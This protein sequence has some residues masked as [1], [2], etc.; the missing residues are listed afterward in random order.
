MKII[1]FTANL[2][3]MIARQLS[4]KLIAMREKYPVLF[5]TG[6]RQSGKTT[7]LNSIFSDL[8]YF[9]LEESDVRRFA[10]NDPRGFL[11]NLP[12][13]AVLDEAQ[14]VPELFSYI[15]SIVDQKPGVHFVL[16][17][18]QNFLLS[19]QISQ[20]LAGR[21]S[22]QKLLPLSFT[23]LKSAGTT[24]DSLDELLHKGGYPRLYAKNLE[25]VDFFPSYIETYLQR[26]VR[27]LKN[28]GDLDRFVQFMGL[29]AGRNGQILNMQSL[30]N[31]AGISPNTAK[32]WLSVLQASYIVFLL[33]PYH[34]NFNKRI[35][36]TSKLYFY[37]TGLAASLLGLRRQED[38]INYHAKGAL[39]ENFAVVEMLKKHWNQG[40]PMD[41][42]FWQDHTGRE[43]D[44]LVQSGN[45]FNAYEVKSGQTFNTS[46]FSNLKYWQSL[47]GA[48]PENCAVLYGGEQSFNT[49]N[50]RL[51]GW[52]DWLS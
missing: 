4:D 38:L 45:I 11:S 2:K 1:T 30:A 14:R 26:D 21:T 43:I 35:T 33:P 27:L 52:R 20:S 8:P 7:L 3:R 39:F 50:G 46:F 48:L 15:Q 19:D 31:D 22:V 25:P 42:W 24:I 34:V 5:L 28:V 23:E 40:I 51:I 12:K 16:S 37:D 29:C 18:S 10:L 6:P 13:G 9:S 49:S 32:S 36:K 47:S 41:A 17:G 44:L